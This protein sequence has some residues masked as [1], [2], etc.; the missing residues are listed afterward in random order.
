MTRSP[1]RVRSP[2]SPLARGEAL[3]APPRPLPAASLPAPEPTTTAAA[4]RSRSQRRRGRARRRAVPRPR[5]RSRPTSRGPPRLRLTALPPWPPREE[6]ARGPVSRPLRRRRSTQA[7]GGPRVA[8]LRGARM[9]GRRSAASSP[10]RHSPPPQPPQPRARA[11]PC[12][13]RRRRRDRSRAPLPMICQ[14]P[15]GR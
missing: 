13:R 6:A 15:R 2:P 9:H 10:P 14:G 3:P 8:A 7:R 1:P 5:L 11:L 4:A 12:P